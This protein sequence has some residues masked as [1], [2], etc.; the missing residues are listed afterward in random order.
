MSMHITYL[1][2]L[3]TDFRPVQITMHRFVDHV[4]DR[5]EA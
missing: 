4:A 1:G 2:R 3:L 5:I